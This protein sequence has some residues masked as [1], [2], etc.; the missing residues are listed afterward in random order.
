MKRP[1]LTIVAAI[2]LTAAITSTTSYSLLKNWVKQEIAAQTIHFQDLPK[3]PVVLA[4]QQR[5]NVG[6][7][8]SPEDFVEVSHRVT[9]GV[10]NI[11]AFT[12]SYQA[13]GGSGV[14]ISP[15]GFIITNNHVVEGASNFEVTLFDRRAVPAELIGTDPTTDLALIKV[16]LDHLTPIPFGNSDAMDVGEWVLAIG[17]PF[18]LASTVTA[19][20][21]SAKGRN[22]NILESR[23]SIESFIQTDAV[24]NPGNSG[25]A[26]VNTRGELIGINTAIMSEGG[27]YEGYSFAIPSNLV[28][29]VITDLKEFG[30]V[31][32]ALLGVSIQE[33]TN[34]M[35]SQLDLPEVAGV[36]ITTIN[37]GGSA[38]QAGLKSGDVIIRL[39]GIRTNSV[40]ELQEQV[41][42]FRPGDLVR[43]DFIRDGQ[44]YAFENVQLQGMDGSMSVRPMSKPE[45]SGKIEKKFNNGSGF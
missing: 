39:N 3:R 14:I 44:A 30:D 4:N 24:V 23:Y 5:V 10:V 42:R 25:G 19:G 11:T 8:E 22:I 16:D 34:D 31:Q 33:I 45:S 43:I 6:P 13:S 2:I 12:G 7:T 9:P 35:A 32:R 36:L 15:D 18:N 17:N 26:L 29:K 37:Q 27:G 21:I 38:A 41:A 28:S 20:I 40:P 1:T